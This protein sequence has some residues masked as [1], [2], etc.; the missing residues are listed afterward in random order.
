MFEINTY[1]CIIIITNLNFTIMENKYLWYKVVSPKGK[2]T[3]NAFTQ[4]ESDYL[5]S[6]GYSLDVVSIS[7][8]I[9]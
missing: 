3:I 1:L 8:T 7:Y 4:K 6:I 2:K 9:K 5:K